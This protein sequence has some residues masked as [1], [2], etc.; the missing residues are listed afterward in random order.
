M[1]EKR[2]KTLSCT[3]VQSTD[4]G[5]GVHPQIYEDNIIKK[6]AKMAQNQLNIPVV[7]ILDKDGN[8]ISF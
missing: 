2:T 7:F 8:S 3:V 5:K 4:F 1:A 6:F